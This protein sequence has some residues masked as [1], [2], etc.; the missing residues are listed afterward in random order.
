MKIPSTIL[1]VLM[2]LGF[3]ISGCYLKVVATTP[4]DN[5]SYV[6]VDNNFY[7][8]FDKPV[9][10]ST[11]GGS[12]IELTS[13][14]GTVPTN[15]QLI[16][17]IMVSIDPASDLPPN[18]AHK[19]TLT[20]QIKGKFGSVLRENID[21]PFKTEPPRSA[22]GSGPDPPGSASPGDFRAGVAEV[23]MTTPISVPL[24]GYGGGNRRRLPPDP[25][26]YDNPY[27]FLNPSTGLKDSIWVKALVLDNHIERVCIVT[28]DTIGTDEMLVRMA[29]KK[30]KDLGFT[31]PLKKVMV[32]SSH[33]HSG[34]GAMIKGMLWQMAAADLYVEAVARHI[35]DKI[36]EA[37]FNA[38][39]NLGLASIGV[40]K[41][42]V[43]GATT[44]RRHN[45]SP[46]LQP[47]SVDPEMIVIR[48]DH[49]GGAPL[50]TVWNFAIHGTH[51]D[52]SNMDYS[53]DI[54]G[55]AS[56]KAKAGGAGVALFINGAE[57]DISPTGDFNTTSTLLANKILA[58]RSAATP[59]SS[60]ILQS[61]SEVVDMGIPNINL[62]LQHLTENEQ[63][64]VLIA[65]ING[66][67]WGP[68]INFP[69][70]QGWVYSDF[71]YQ[72]IRLD[73]TVIVS[74]PG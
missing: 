56:I 2:M 21:I 17:P 64:V 46:A 40:G 65:A 70:P 12:A 26:E 1:V 57:G 24:A 54:M 23:D 10:A 62:G 32:C 51:L 4:T 36:A 72:A 14:T 69:I 39:Q 66:A 30:A 15:V 45:L 29:H 31:V 50:A 74:M 59:A 18:T 3:S 25:L 13:A 63:A 47:D 19:L 5:E 49:P 52:S 9:D 48:V 73:K 43:T 20:N 61:T 44:N 55:A 28:L 7:A 34:P 58:A 6:A 35:S 16:S 68:T 67:G 8:M 22:T 71:R 60:G 41:S 11:I 38:E 27:T 33:T 37:M 42:T 53:A